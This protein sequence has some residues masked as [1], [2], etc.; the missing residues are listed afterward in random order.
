MKYKKR[1]DKLSEDI[2]ATIN[3]GRILEEVFKT[4]ID[5]QTGTR[6]EDESLES[7]LQEGMVD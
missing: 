5:R 1:V 6:R 3:Q 7:R 4:S 2:E